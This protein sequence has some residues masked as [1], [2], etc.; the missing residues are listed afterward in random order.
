MNKF[1]TA[2]F[3]FLLCFNAMSQTDFTQ[4]TGD[5]KQQTIQVIS[6]AS[7]QMTT[8]TCDFVQEKTSTLV[9]EKAVS[10]GKMYFQNPRSLRW[11]YTFP[12]SFVLIMKGTDVTVKNAQGVVTQ[13]TR[14][15]KELANIIVSIVDGSG[16]NDN[17]N[18]TSQVFANTNDY[19]VK[20]IPTNKRL[21]SMYSDITLLFNKQ[22]KY[23]KSITMHEKNGDTMTITFLNHKINQPIDTKLFIAQ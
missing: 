8:I 19:M 21:S 1:F 12:N 18:F 13:N 15:F 14:M 10:K 4:I 5:K 11:E 3:A 17:K 16:L 22:T 9:A 6:K 23:A 7:K 20:L 2:I